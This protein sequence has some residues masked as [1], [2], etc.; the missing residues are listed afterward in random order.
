MIITDGKKG[1]AAESRVNLISSA[2]DQNLSVELSSPK[3]LYT[4]GSTVTGIVHLGN[5]NHE[6]IIE[7]NAAIICTVR[8]HCK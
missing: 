4:A 7:V 6:T 8:S 2:S 3:Q 1:T 5:K